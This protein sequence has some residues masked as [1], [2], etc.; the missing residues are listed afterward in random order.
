[1][2]KDKKLDEYIECESDIR[3]PE[4][5]PIQSYPF[6]L[7]LEMQE[8]LASQKCSEK[9]QAVILEIKIMLEDRL[10]FQQAF[11]EALKKKKK[12]LSME[13]RLKHVLGRDFEKKSDQV[14]EAYKISFK[15]YDFTTVPREE[16]DV[17][18][19]FLEMIGSDDLFRIDRL[20]L[21]VH[22]IVC[23][24]HMKSLLSEIL[25]DIHNKLTPLVT[26]ELNCLFSI[27]DK[28]NSAR[29]SEKFIPGKLSKKYLKYISKVLDKVRDEAKNIQIRIER[30]KLKY[31]PQLNEIWK[32]FDEIIKEAEAINGLNEVSTSSLTEELRQ[33]SDD[34]M[35]FTFMPVWLLIREKFSIAYPIYRQLQEINSFLDNFDSSTPVEEN[36]V[37]AALGIVPKLDTTFVENPIVLPTYDDH[38][39]QQQ[40]IT[41]AFVEQKKQQLQLWKERIQQRKE[42]QELEQQLNRAG[43]EKPSIEEKVEM[44]SKEASQL[45]T[46]F[47]MMNKSNKRTFNL[48]FDHNYKGHNLPIE[49]IKSLIIKIGGKINSN[50]GSHFSIELPNTYRSDASFIKSGSY[51]PHGTQDKSTQSAYEL[52]QEAFTKAG[53]TPER[54]EMAQS[55]NKRTNSKKR[56]M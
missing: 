3:P 24:G 35:D 6:P 12:C 23:S 32:S 26:E 5:P 28:K 56:E 36:L 46:I 11:L 40:A 27:V 8:E 42:A 19:T 29:L 48:L 51:I 18:K 38:T 10:K 47:E 34:F 13:D 15:D 4:K 33:L 43:L 37:S 14:K 49:D 25:S 31:G 16:I 22:F 1:M 17:L 55:I 50:S 52:C 9:K 39:I 2:P 21:T 44:D 30:C 45:L 53:I 41:Y 54:I 7:R 20:Y